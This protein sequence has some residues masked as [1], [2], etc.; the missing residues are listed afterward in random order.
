MLTAPRASVLLQNLSK[1]TPGNKVLLRF[2]LKRHKP[3]LLIIPSELKPRRDCAGTTRKVSAIKIV[4]IAALVASGL[5][6]LPW[7]L[8]S[9]WPRPRLKTIV[10]VAAVRKRIE[11]IRTWARSPVITLIRRAILPTNALS[12][13]SQTT[14]IGFANLLVGD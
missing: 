7:P 13:V 1:N 2:A 14:N 5:K 3:W 10:I 8:R 6:I 11:K 4:A 12:S 9:T